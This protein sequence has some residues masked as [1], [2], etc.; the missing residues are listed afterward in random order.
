MIKLPFYYVKL[1]S[2]QNRFI[3][4]SQLI[5][6]FL[7]LRKIYKKLFIYQND[8]NEQVMKIYNN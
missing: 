6:I 7:K 8:L 2:S 1:I 5:E 4:F 3:D